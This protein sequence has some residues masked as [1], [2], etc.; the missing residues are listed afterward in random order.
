MGDAQFLRIPGSGGPSVS[1][2]CLQ[3]TWTEYN[4]QSAQ[5]TGQPRPQQNVGLVRRVPHRATWSRIASYVKWEAESR[6]AFAIRRFFSSGEMWR[7]L[8][9]TALYAAMSAEY[10][11]L[12]SASAG[13]GQ[14]Q[15]QCL[16]DAAAKRTFDTG[17]IVPVETGV[18]AEAITV[19]PNVCLFRA[20]VW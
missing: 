2:G 5:P 10:A 9:T 11:D 4:A 18:Y 16:D 1:P 14:G 20:A 6:A 17:V 8:L 7:S 15:K 3:L 19:Q 13:H 12:H